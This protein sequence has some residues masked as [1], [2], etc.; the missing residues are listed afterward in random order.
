MRGID[1]FVVLIKVTVPAGATIFSGVDG[2]DAGRGERR[3]VDVGG[4]VTEELRALTRSSDY[5]IGVSRT[6]GRLIAMFSVIYTVNYLHIFS[7]IVTPY[8]DPHFFID[9]IRRVSLLEASSAGVREHHDGAE[10]LCG[11]TV[12]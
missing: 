11:A 10:H 9:E 12:P 8:I 3:R 1:C 5:W 4:G 6:T 2:F 7:I